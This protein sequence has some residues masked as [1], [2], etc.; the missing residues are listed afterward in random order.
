MKIRIATQNDINQIAKVHVDS[1]RSTYKKILSSEYLNSLSYESRAK[2]WKRRL[3]S[4]E[5]DEFMFVAENERNEIIGFASG[6]SCNSSPEYDGILYTLYIL[7]EYQKKGIGK[8]LFNAMVEEF[9]ALGIK[10]F[11]LWVFDSNSATKF[12]ERMGGERFDE[13]IEEVGGYTLKEC[14]YIFQL[15]LPNI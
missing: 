15:H 9:K 2:N 11:I 13:R 3:F 12:Y 10:S 4:N 6:C 7:E 1:W 8:L 14:S 5:F